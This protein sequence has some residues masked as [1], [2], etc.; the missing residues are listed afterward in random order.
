M[1]NSRFNQSLDTLRMAQNDSGKPA[2]ENRKRTIVRGVA[3]DAE[4]RCA[5]WHGLAD[6]VAI[7]FRC[8]GEYFAC[9]DCHVALADHAAQVWPRA[10]FSAL[11]VRCGACGNEQ[12]IAS[13]LADHSD[14]PACHAEFN[15][16]CALHHPLYFEE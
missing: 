7:K 3:M 1:R 10:D 9:H 16:R 14:C 5:H 4:T 12:S 13:Y 15:P 8:C 6:I 11:A 2:K